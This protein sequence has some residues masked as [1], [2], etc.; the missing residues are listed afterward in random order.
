MSAMSVMSRCR[1]DE[2]RV[3]VQDI[4]SCKSIS[5]L[6]SLVRVPQETTYEEKVEEDF[7]LSPIQRIYF[8]CM[9][10]NV[11]HFNQSMMVNIGVALEPREIKKS[12]EILVKTHSMLRA[13]F[14]QGESS[15]WTQRITNE[16]TQSY[17]FEEH[18]VNDIGEMAEIIHNSQKSLNVMKG[19]VI[20]IDLFK[21][22]ADKSQLFICIH[23]LVVDVVSW[24]ILLQDLEDLLRHG[25]LQMTPAI[26]FQKWCSL[27]LDQAQI[28]S[29][30][31][32]LPIED[33]PEADYAY[34]GM[35]DKPNCYGNTITE[36]IQIDED[37]TSQLLATYSASHQVDLVDVIIGTLLVSFSRVFT[38]RQLLPIIF[39][40]SHGREPWD[41]EI[42]IS[43]TLGWFTAMSPIYLPKNHTLREGMLTYLPSQC[44]RGSTKLIDSS[45]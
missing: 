23:H 39:N 24:G 5:H 25:K 32:V 29:T 2:M 38:D 19:P 16:I 26:S 37:M 36:H 15:V 3:T 31:T 45:R 44:T 35:T 1:S 20:H 22:P 28:Q 33:A 12:I 4:I 42:D 27:Q 17:N 13:R 41:S 8:Q 21:L 7:D 30:S 34:W 40:E 43:R 18:K 14:S 9:N 10:G 11:N 6:A